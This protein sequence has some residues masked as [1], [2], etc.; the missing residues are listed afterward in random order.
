LPAVRRRNS[1]AAIGPDN[2]NGRLDG[3][4]TQQFH[5]LAATLAVVAL[6]GGTSAQSNAT[7]LLRAWNTVSPSSPSTTIEVW[8]AWDDPLNQYMF[9]GADYDLTAGDGLFSDP[10][11]I[12]QGPGSSPGI[13]NANVVTGGTNGA[14]WYPN[15]IHPFQGGPNLLASYTWTATDFT[16]RTVDLFTSNTTN[17]I[18]VL[19][20]TGQA[21]QLF[22]A[23]FTPGSGG[24]TVVPAPAVWWLLALPLAAISRRRSSHV[25]V[26]VFNEPPQGALT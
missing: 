8:A 2:V 4:K 9:G 1:A 5:V 7:F 12:Q 15:P 25:R 21:T 22:P 20:S 17:F 26:G 6:A 18:V 3:M 24:I 19:K 16:P 14:L 10:I 13:A 11:N 23:L